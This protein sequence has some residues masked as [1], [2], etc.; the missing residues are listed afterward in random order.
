MTIYIAAALLLLA[1][2]WVFGQSGSNFGSPAL[3]KILMVSAPILLL[4]WALS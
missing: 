2:V 4:S 3:G 1:G